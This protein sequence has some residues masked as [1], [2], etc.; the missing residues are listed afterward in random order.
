MTCRIMIVEDEYWTAMDMATEVEERGGAVTGPV[1]TVS[2]AMGLLQD[3]G[4]PDAAILD[5]SL[6]G[7]DVYPFADILVRRGI[8]FVFA[9]GYEQ[10]VIPERFSSAPHFEKPVN[11]SACAE[12]VL[13][14]AA[15]RQTPQSGRS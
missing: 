8:P 15:G 14:L 12:A 4:G 9:T 10:E 5:V 13:T 11:T 7:F 1:A 2:G 6:H 3:E